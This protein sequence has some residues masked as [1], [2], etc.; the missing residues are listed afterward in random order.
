MEERYTDIWFVGD[1]RMP[2]GPIEAPNGEGCCSQKCLSQYVY[3]LCSEPEKELLRAFARVA[4]TWSEETRVTDAAW[5]LR[6]S[7]IA[8]LIDARALRAVDTEMKEFTELL[9][10][11]DE[12]PAWYLEAAGL[13]APRIS[14]AVV[15]LGGAA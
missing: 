13:I 6:H 10:G 8:W 9:T 14:P 7:G 2:G 5:C 3:S 15:T 4:N 12:A 1:N 11:D